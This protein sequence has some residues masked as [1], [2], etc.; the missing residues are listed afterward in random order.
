M[1][2]PEEV[3][4]FYLSNKLCF[5]CHFLSKKEKKKKT[6]E[7]P[8]PCLSYSC[9]NSPSVLFSTT[10]PHCSGTYFPMAFLL[11]GLLS[12]C[13][14]VFSVLL[15]D[16]QNSVFWV[17]QVLHWYQSLPFVLNQ[18]C[19]SLYWESEF[20][21]MCKYIIYNYWEL[22]AILFREW[23]LHCWDPHILFQIVL[24]STCDHNIVAWR[25]KNYL[26]PSSIFPQTH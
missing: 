8:I 12:L 13:P 6:E 2:Y 21:L 18:I 16:P 1:A 10:L 4:N 5:Q 7:P 24:W 26:I 22:C 19:Q 11:P 25:S 17:I 9:Q 15:I 14:S 23:V 3:L 20:R